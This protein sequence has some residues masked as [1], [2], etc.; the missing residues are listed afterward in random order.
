MRIFEAI[1]ATVLA[2]LAAAAPIRQAAADEPAQAAFE[3]GFEA[4]RAGQIDRAIPALIEAAATGRDRAKFFAEFYLARI[5]S[6]SAAGIAS[7]P[8]AFM[9]FRKLADENAEVDPGDS[10]RAPFVAKALIA[11]AGYT[12]TGLSEMDLAPNPRR[13]TDYLN[14]A[15]TYFGDKEA[16]VELAKVY[17]S[18]EPSKDDVRRGMHYLSTLSEQSNPA[19]QALLA[20]VFWRGRHVRKDEERALAL[21]TMAVENAPQHERMW[22]EDSYHTIFCACSP[23]TRKGAEG[24]VSRWKNFFARPMQQ[25]ADRTGLGNRE[26]LP[27]RQCAD[28]EVA[29]RHG[30]R[31]GAIAAAPAGPREA[32]QGSAASLGFS[33]K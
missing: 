3:R 14:H 6:E 26:M 20:E 13:A 29:V 18:G 8:K 22:I 5:Y 7:H 33:A 2:G 21:M 32:V 25:P 24:L 16:Q 12:R 27:E 11:L 17:L 31:T 1:F 15:A 9:L 10:E 30:L 19:A 28:G 4:Y 23:E